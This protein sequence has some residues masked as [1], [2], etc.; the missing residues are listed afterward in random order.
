MLKYWGLETSRFQ[1]PA[2]D[3]QCVGYIQASRHHSMTRVPPS[4]KHFKDP[5]CVLRGGTQQSQCCI[6]KPEAALLCLHLGTSQPLSQITMK[7]LSTCYISPSSPSCLSFGPGETSLTQH[8]IRCPVQ[9][10][11]QLS[12]FS[13]YSLCIYT[14]Y[15]CPLLFGLEPQ[16][17]FNTSE[18]HNLAPVF[19]AVKLQITQNCTLPQKMLLCRLLLGN[20]NLY[21]FCFHI[22]ETKM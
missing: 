2:P 7:T 22:L 18:D 8:P 17:E 3:Q 1:N 16:T 14:K 12:H 19:D 4:T 15:S 20:P 10:N 6:H 9:A 13:V 11:Q 21:H 5:G